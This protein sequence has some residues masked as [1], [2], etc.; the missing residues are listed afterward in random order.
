M[1]NLMASPV[2]TS[3]ITIDTLTFNSDTVG[4]LKV[5]VDNETA[6]AFNADVAITGNGNDVK[7]AGK[8]YTG[9]SRM[10]LKLNINNFNM[11][12]V[13]PFTFGA[14]TQA[15]GSLKGDVSLK[16]TTTKPDVNGS[17]HFE[18]A[19]ITPA[20][21]G[22][23]LHL[24]NE[25]ILVSSRDIS[26]DHFT[27][28]DSAGNKAMLDGNI[29]TSDY[30]TFTFD[31]TLTAND[32]R[33][34][35]VA[36]SQSALYYGRL[37]M[38]AD[39]NV[40]GSL[41]APRV[42]AY[43]KINR[44]TDITFVLPSSNPELESREGVVQFIDVDGAQKDSV[45]KAAIDTLTRY[46]KLAGLDITTTLESDTAAQITLII[47]ERS[48]D[49]LRIRGKAD[50]A[51]GFDKSG[52]ISLTGNYELQ[53]GSYQLS[54]SLLKRQFIIQPGS[55]LTW[56][57]DPLSATVDITAIYIANTQPVNLL[58]SEL[59]N[60]AAT[61]INKY[62]AKVPFNV[63]LKMKGELLKPVITFDIELPD[64]Q[65]SKWADVE[66]KLEQIRKDDAE[67]NKQ[68]FALLLLGRFVQENPLENS[69]EGATLASTARTSVSR[70]LTEQL[71]N[72]AG[73][74][75]KGVDLNFGVN[76]EDDYSTG[77]RTNRTDLTV[78]V[79]KSLLNDRLRVNVGS[80]FELE[81]PANTNQSASNIAGD[82]AVDYL[83]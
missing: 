36:K 71:N 18:N 35:N 39:I 1:K 74:L 22:E 10:D 28:T 72:L 25:V 58:Q 78:G 30:K 38:D 60:L 2:F 3:D 67:L 15:D 43:L 62:K 31:L 47:D 66:N 49:A 61:D 41:T 56:T 40:E 48:G 19:N 79:S 33:V 8:Y 6:N 12:S 37:N 20:A 42:D 51:A 23:K 29:F 21:T 55:V 54:L 5:K 70:I 17:L 76:S 68:V 50:L 7:L 24:S 53:N 69:A 14:L 46:P 64:D 59:A 83:L 73:S 34:L 45:F 11:A 81:G 44:A 9:E 16:G 82:V 65:K 26:F 80:N 75:I 57:G 77:T 32:F 52:K 13:R 4:N 63:L 27:L